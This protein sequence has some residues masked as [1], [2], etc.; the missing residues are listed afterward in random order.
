MRTRLGLLCAALIFVSSPV[1]C[2]QQVSGTLTANGKSAQLKYALAMEVDSK[3]EPGYLDVV[4]VLSDRKLS[5]RDVASEDRLAELTTRSGLA[6]VRLLIDP[7]AKLKSATAYHRAFTAFI[8]SGAFARWKPSA[9]NEKSVAG[10]VT[11]DGERNEFNN[12]W[13]YDLT[14][15]APIVLDPEAKT[16]P[17]KPK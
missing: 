3:S 14:F 13:Q 16:V 12:R 15:S 2:A 10:R 8:S 6:A 17:I 11:T 5:P 1:V 7:D 9:Y 4:V